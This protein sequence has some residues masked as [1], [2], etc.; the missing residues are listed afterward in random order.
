MEEE[1]KK[2]LFVFIFSTYLPVF[3]LNFS[4][5]EI[6]WCV[7]WLCIQQY[8]HFII[9]TDRSTP[10]TR[11]TWKNM[12]MISS[13]HFSGISCFWGR[14][15]RQKYAVWVLIGYEIKLCIQQTLLLGILVKTQGD[16]SKI[17]TKESSFVLW[18]IC[19]FNHYGWLI[20]LKFYWFLNCN[21][22]NLLLVYFLIRP[23]S[24]P[25]FPLI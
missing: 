3:L 5:R 25:K 7:I 22:Q 13:S 19:Q 8:P 10:K 2:L 4:L 16:M 23:I 6:V 21:S 14:G 12:M 20:L 17:Q 15:V 18:Q 11:K 24:D 9:L 1:R